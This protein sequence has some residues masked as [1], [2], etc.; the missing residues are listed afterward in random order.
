MLELLYSA[1]EANSLNAE[2]VDAFCK[3][4]IKDRIDMEE[5]FFKAI[6][7]THREGFKEGLKAALH[8][9]GD[10]R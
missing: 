7:D 6:S 3:K 5:Q 10:I 9:F 2:S 4:F 1:V 8:L